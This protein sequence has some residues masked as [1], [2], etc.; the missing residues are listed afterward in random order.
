[1]LPDD[2]RTTSNKQIDDVYEAGNQAQQNM[3]KIQRWEQGMA[4]NQGALAPGAFNELRTDAANMWNTAM[5][6]AGHPEYKLDGLEDAQIAQKT[7]KGAAAMGEAANQQRSF[8]A[9]KAFLQQTPNP[10]MQRG[11]ALP[12][13]A[14]LH[15]ENQVAIDRKNY[16]DEFD[17]ENQRSYGAPVPRN[18]LASDAL[19]AFDK[20]YPANNYQ[21]ERNKLS[22]ILQSQG[23]GK[24]QSDLQNASPDKKQK[25]YDALDAKYGPN[26]HRYFT[27][28]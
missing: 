17:K 6:Q 10:E 15:A 9:L 4:A 13:I 11:A 24:L 1:M 14:D 8:N 26:F 28:S 19:Q 18:Y 5:D 23:Y 12:L 3:M 25:L 7:S 22:T 20:D 2:A 21:G 16:V 27:G